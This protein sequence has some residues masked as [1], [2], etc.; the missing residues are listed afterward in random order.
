MV[1]SHI[2]KSWI[3]LALMHPHTSP[4]AGFAPFTDNLLHGLFHL[5][6]EEHWHLFSPKT[7][8]NVNLSDHRTR[9]H[10]LSGRLTWAWAQRTHCSVW[11]KY[12]WDWLLFYFSALKVSYLPQTARDHSFFPQDVTLINNWPHSFGTLL[13]HEQTH[14]QPLQLQTRA[15]HTN[16]NLET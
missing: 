12:A 16:R 8:W 13:L 7:S 15:K 4:D 14:I 3:L 2:H 1:A 10:C 5:W 11:T 6:C 9:F